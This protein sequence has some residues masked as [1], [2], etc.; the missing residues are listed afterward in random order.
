VG[1]P[2]DG[3]LNGEVAVC[4][5]STGEVYVNYRNTDHRAAPRYRLYSRS[6]DGGAGFYQE[7]AEEDLP[8]HGCN[9]GLVSFTAEGEERPFFM[10]LTYP[11]EPSRQKLTCYV[12]SD[13]GQSWAETKVISS[14]GGYSDVA[15]LRDRII[16]VLYEQSRAAGLHLAR[17]RLTQK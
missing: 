2:A 5:T 13:D 7:G 9:A 3:S 6:R 10:L 1:F 12:S 16:L 8:A 4:E 11:L 17:F 15:V 14:G